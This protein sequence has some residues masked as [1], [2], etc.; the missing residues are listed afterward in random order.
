MY[1]GAGAL[2]L[3]EYADKKQRTLDCKTDCSTSNCV[4]KGGAGNKGRMGHGVVAASSDSDELS[5]ENARQEHKRTLSCGG[6]QEPQTKKQRTDHSAEVSH[7]PVERVV[8][9]D[10]TWHQVNKIKNDERL[11]GRY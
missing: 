5:G 7:L 8:F 3:E 1:P 10:S 2:T 9:I 4:V 11:A 6:E